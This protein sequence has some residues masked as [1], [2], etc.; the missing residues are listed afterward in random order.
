MRKSRDLFKI[1][2]M[3]V[4][5]VTVL[6]GVVFWLY[7]GKKVDKSEWIV[8]IP[9]FIIV[10]FAAIILVGRIKN[11]KDKIVAEDEMS[12]IVK[13]KAGNTSFM[14]SVYGWLIIWYIYNHYYQEE[15]IFGAGIMFMALSYFVSYMIHSK[16]GHRSE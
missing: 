16:I 7:S 6:L 3:S 2:A 1:I 5:I 14:I 8:F 10:V 15:S 11:W 13:L 4:L 12:K 9:L